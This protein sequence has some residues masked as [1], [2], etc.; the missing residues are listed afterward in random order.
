ML[1]MR[2]RKLRLASYSAASTLLHVFGG[3]AALACAEPLI[4]AACADL[5]AEATA[6]PVPP[7]ARSEQPQP[8]PHKRQRG[9][10]APSDAAASSAAAA[11]PAPRRDVAMQL[12]AARAL[13][14]L[15]HAGAAG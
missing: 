11:L 4:A 9:A 7:P 15:L 2:C 1:P 5:S 8:Q 3:S 13:A 14:A 10:D 6:P 12:A